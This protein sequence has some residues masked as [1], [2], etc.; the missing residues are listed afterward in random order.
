MDYVV[1]KMNLDPKAYFQGIVADE[2]K[3]Y[4]K[5]GEVKAIWNHGVPPLGDGNLMLSFEGTTDGDIKYPV[6][7]L[8]VGELALSN[9]LEFIYGEQKSTEVSLRGGKTVE[10][11]AMGL[12][13]LLVNK[14]LDISICGKP[15]L[16]LKKGSSF[17]KVECTIPSID[18]LFSNYF[19]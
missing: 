10:I 15:C 19:E 6:M 3:V 9:P 12:N 4:Q 13:S 1:G 8:A 17:Q 5:T 11:E 14:K 2:T 16:D 18:T 7:H